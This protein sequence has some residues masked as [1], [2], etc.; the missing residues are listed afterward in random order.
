MADFAYAV[1]TDACTYLLDDTGV[2]LWVLSPAPTTANAV[3]ACVG[4]QF[5]AC[6]DTR[7]EGGLVGEIVEGAAA[8]F[9]AISKTTGRPALLRTGPIRRVQERHPSQ[10]QALVDLPFEDIDQHFGDDDSQRTTVVS[11]PPAAIAAPLDQERPTDKMPRDLAQDGLTP[12]AERVIGDGITAEAPTRDVAP[13]G[14]PPHP[15]AP[16]RAAKPPP[17]PMPQGATPLP[18]PVAPPPMPPPLPLSKVPTIPPMPSPRLGPPPLPGA[19]PGAVPPIPAA[20]SPT[21]P[22]LPTSVER[23][24][25]G[26]LTPSDEKSLATHV[27]SPREE[28]EIATHV[29]SPR[30][31]EEIATHVTSPRE[32]EEIAT[33]VTS[34]GGDEDLETR[35]KQHRKGGPPPLPRDDGSR[36]GASRGPK[37]RAERDESVAPA[38][39]PASRL[40]SSPSAPKGNRGAS[41]K[42][43]VPPPV[44]PPVAPPPPRESAVPRSTHFDENA[45]LPLRRRKKRD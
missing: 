33:H 12:Q 26:S 10:V 18:A 9:V 13:Q 17:L 15:P 35:V 14:D 39:F 38:S 8:L 43:P 11:E 19:K 25:A 45:P 32:E 2:C 36:T 23:P 34:P 28:E 37:K 1:H 40:K 3:K 16:I 6:I 41:G 21:V 44:P 7:V 5:V 4:A 20:K 22:P 30:E 27:T 29:T 24:G 42:K 31:E